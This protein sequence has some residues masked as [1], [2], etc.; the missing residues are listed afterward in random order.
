MVSLKKKPV[1][2]RISEKLSHVKTGILSLAALGFCELLAID[3]FANYLFIFSIAESGL[4][5]GASV[6]VALLSSVVLCFSIMKIWVHH[7]GR[8]Y[9]EAVFDGALIG[10]AAG[11]LVSL[12]LLLLG[13][14][15]MGAIKLMRKNPLPGAEP[16]IAVFY[17]AACAAVLGLYVFSGA[18]M[19]VWTAI[20]APILEKKM[21]KKIK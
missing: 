21:E 15:G 6:L 11:A 13:S 4:F 19:G 2:M 20:A 3:I 5:L 18:L 10:A 7:G 16:G 12:L 9:S 1:C 14:L 17:L 8:H